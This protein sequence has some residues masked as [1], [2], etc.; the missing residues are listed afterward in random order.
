MD[1]RNH[2]NQAHEDNMSPD[3]DP[4][5]WAEAAGWARDM[6]PTFYAA[7]LSFGIA[8]L[9]IV[10]EDGRAGTKR[11]KKQIVIE[12]LLCGGLT[13]A[14]VSLMELVGVPVTAAAGVGGMLGFLGVD[15]VRALAVRF[16][17][18]KT[19]GDQGTTGPI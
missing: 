4:T 6:L 17:E 1:K 10:Y 11:P 5:F 19:G 2:T 16:L 9:R 8:T 18:K 13:V 12:A 3:K 7:G 15:R 14:A